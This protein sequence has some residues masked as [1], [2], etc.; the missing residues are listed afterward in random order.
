MW[1]CFFTG[2][3]LN[4]VGDLMKRSCTKEIQDEGI[5]GQGN[6]SHYFLDMEINVE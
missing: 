2:Q 3:G 4:A 1:D 6:A 5:V